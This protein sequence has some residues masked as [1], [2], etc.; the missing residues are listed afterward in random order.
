MV[1]YKQIGFNNQN[2]NSSYSGI[3]QQELVISLS[4][5]NSGTITKF[6]IQLGQ[7][8]RKG[9]LLATLDNV[10]ARLAYEQAVTQ[11][12]AAKSNFNTAKLA[13]ER[14]RKLYEKSGASLSDFEQAKNA[15]QT[16]KE[17]YEASKR[18][19]AIQQ[20]QINYGYIYAPQDGVIAAVNA[21][22]N[23]NIAAGQSVATLNAGKGMEI[24]VG[25][26]ENVINT[27]KEGD[28]T[29]VFLVSLKDQK[30]TGKVIEVAPALSQESATYTVRVVLENV[31]DTVKSGM[32]ADVYFRNSEKGKIASML[33]VPP[34]AVGEDYNG[35]YVFLIQEKDSVLIVKKHPI[36]VGNLMQN[37]FEVQSGVRKGDRIAVAGLHTLLDGQVIRLK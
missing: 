26:P 29:D 14:A 34:Q 18:T 28:V 2:A 37:G 21:E 35:N 7:K 15:F 1:K 20:D 4:F 19:V 9:E 11:K 36:T 3:T 25:V 33:I 32:A 23:E 22:I 17:N 6:N 31:T 8:V 30:F 13:L 16:A 12:N 27:I 10:S 5:R 24:K